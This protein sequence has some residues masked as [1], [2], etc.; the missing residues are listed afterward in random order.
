MDGPPVPNDRRR[1][2]PRATLG[3]LQVPPRAPELRL[4]HERLDS[5]SGIDLVV[6]GMAHQRFQVSLGEQGA[7]SG[8]PCSSTSAMTKYR[9]PLSKFT[10]FVGTS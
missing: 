2:L 7:A 4:M 6:V 3:F 8:S 1:L 10:R 5:L 9:T